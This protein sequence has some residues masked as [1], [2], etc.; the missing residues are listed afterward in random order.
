MTTS[1]VAA[2]LL[3]GSRMAHSRFEIPLQTTDAIVTRMSK[4]SGRAKLIQKAK[5]IIWDKAPM[6]SRRTIKTVDRSFRDIL[7]INEP[8]GVKIMV[9]GGDFR[10]VLPVIPKSTRAEIGESRTFLSFDS[11]EDDTNNYYQEDY[12]N[13]LTPNGLPPHRFRRYTITLD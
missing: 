7:D 6:A 12:L 5:L 3:L 8:F 2:T 11:T 4:Q 13:T 9:F 1:G 10:Q